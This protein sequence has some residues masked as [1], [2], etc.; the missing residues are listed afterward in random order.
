MT[1]GYH[2]NY[3]HNLGIQ[4]KQFLLETR[5]ASV[6]EIK[7][8]TTPSKAN[9]HLVPSTGKSCERIVHTL[10]TWRTDPR[11]KSCGHKT[12][13]NL[14]DFFPVIVQFYVWDSVLGNALPANFP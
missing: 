14:T 10:C 11:E 4:T 3:S 6:I 8:T 7:Q 1:R 13:H 5:I 2:L 12:R 9:W